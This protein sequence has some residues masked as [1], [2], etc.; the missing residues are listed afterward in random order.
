[1]TTFIQVI[2]TVGSKP[3]AEQLA[4]LVINGRVAACAQISGPMQS[5]Y[6]WK[7]KVETAEEW[8][9][10][11]KTEQ[12]LYTELEEVLSSHH[13]YDVPEILAVP[14]LNGN[15]GYLAWLSDEVKPRTT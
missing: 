7:G 10:T 4:S 15:A 11:F 3:D 14:I 5:V 2:T 8:R 6:W 12:R 1:M 9:I 13:P